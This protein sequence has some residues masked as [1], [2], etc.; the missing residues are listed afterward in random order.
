MAGKVATMLAGQLDRLTRLSPH[1]ALQEALAIARDLGFEERAAEADEDAL[2]IVVGIRSLLVVQRE[3]IVLSD[4]ERQ[5]LHALLQMALVR[6]TEHDELRSVREHMTLLSQASFE[7][8]FWHADG[9]ILGANQRFS[10]LTGYPLSE[11]HGSEVFKALLA[12]E[13]IPRVFQRLAARY[14]GAYVVTCVRKDR[15]RFRAELQAKQGQWGERP[16]RVVAVRDVTERERMEALLSESETRLR[17]LA[18]AIFDVIVY[19]RQGL[20]LDATGSTE[21]LFGRT[22]EQMIGHRV[23]EFVPREFSE[24][25][26]QMHATDT[27]GVYESA[28]LTVTGAE[29]PVEVVAVRTTLRG[30]PVRMAALRDVRELKRQA[31]Q[32]RELEQAVERSQRL[33]SLGVLAGGIAH[34]FNNLLSAVNGYAELLE[35]RLEDSSLR[36]MARSIVEAQTPRTRLDKRPAPSR[37]ARAISPT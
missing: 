33:D 4:I 16:V 32:R 15:T 14:E 3:G 22:R 29:I 21:Q 26:E 20:I 30:E 2:H 8:L 11:V 25:I 18:E 27:G 37:F 10:E 9:F 35:M 36:D 17:Q 12:P 19:S 34:D 1:L 5:L 28:V 31:K 24:S 6:A 23:M 13:D 7:G